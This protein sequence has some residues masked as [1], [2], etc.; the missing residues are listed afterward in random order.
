MSNTACAKGS[1]PVS[2][3]LSLIQGKQGEHRP[4]N[5]HQRRT[6]PPVESKAETSVESS[7]DTPMAETPQP[8][9]LPVPWRTAICLAACGVAVSV[10]GTGKW[11]VGTAVMIRRAHRKTMKCHRLNSLSLL[12]GRG[13]CASNGARF[14][15]WGPRRGS[16]GNIGENIR[17]QYNG[18]NTATSPSAC[19]LADSN[20]PGRLR[21]RGERGGRRGVETTVETAVMIQGRTHRKTMKRHR[22][23][24]LSLLQRKR[25]EHRSSNGHQQRTLP[26]R[27]ARRKHRWKHPVTR[28]CQK[29]CNL[30]ACNLSGRLRVAVSVGEE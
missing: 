14:P 9:R 29:H 4:S 25:R 20:L 15:W 23:N 27:R 24:P 16:G 19:A 26:R 13:R 5:G 1:A 10:G 3:P 6:L 30:T 12:Q 11:G 21:G 7:G 18:R 17:R 22:L 2:I 28:Q 8:H